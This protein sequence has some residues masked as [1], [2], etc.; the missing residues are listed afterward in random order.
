MRKE[1]INGLWAVYNEDERPIASFKFEEDADYFITTRGN[2][3]QHFKIGDTVHYQSEI[4][5]Q[6]GEFEVERVKVTS[7]GKVM[8]MLRGKIFF[9]SDENMTKIQ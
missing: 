1:L 5:G 3:P 2:N 8:Y 7:T 6:S 4:L 9:C